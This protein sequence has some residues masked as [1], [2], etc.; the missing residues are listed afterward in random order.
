M[1]PLVRRNQAV[2]TGVQVG[3]VRQKAE[4]FMDDVNIFSSCRKDLALVDAV[5]R[6]Y[7]ALSCTLHSRSRKTKIMGFDSWQEEKQWELPWVEAVKSMRILGL[8]H[9]FLSRVHRS[10]A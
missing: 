3:P 10:G 4:A 6:R 9:L 1:E 8:R 7:E 5:F 2:T